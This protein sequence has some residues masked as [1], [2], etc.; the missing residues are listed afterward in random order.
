MKNLKV[1][2]LVITIASLIVCT[3]CPEA[4]DDSSDFD[5]TGYW[6]TE[7]SSVEP[8]A[9]I[10][11]KGDWTEFRLD[12]QSESDLLFAYSI[13]NVPDGFNTVWPEGEG[14]YTYD[15]TSKVIKFTASTGVEFEATVT[16]DNFPDDFT[17]QRKPSTN[18]SGRTSGLKDPWIFKM[19]DASDDD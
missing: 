4:G 2:L 8:S 10:T 15:A 7:N 3:G 9:D 5:V 1:A 17:V 14:T 16:D 19:L 18:S 11:E 13:E 6:K 12:L